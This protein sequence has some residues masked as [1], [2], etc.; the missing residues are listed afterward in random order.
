MYLV[1]GHTEILL[2]KK[3]NALRIDLTDSERQTLYDITYMW[4]IQKSIEMNLFVE[5][6]QTHR[7]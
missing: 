5:Q 2:Q 6:N 7:L 4:N 3:K 1:T